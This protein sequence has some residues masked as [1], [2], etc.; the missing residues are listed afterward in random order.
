MSEPQEWPRPIG[1]HDN[2]QRYP[3]PN[4]VT[5]PLDFAAMI[6]TV[7]R[8]KGRWESIIFTCGTMQRDHP[9]NVSASCSAGRGESRSSKSANAIQPWRLLTCTS[10]PIAAVTRRNFISVPPH[11]HDLSPAH[12][13]TRIDGLRHFDQRSSPLRT[14]C[15]LMCPAQPCVAA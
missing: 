3:L 11:P 10:Y 8:G 7:V 6:S 4:V 13:I 15:P 2:L 5:L 12:A 1:R 9:T 14:I